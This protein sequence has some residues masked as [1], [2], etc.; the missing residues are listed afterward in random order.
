M[1]VPQC[2]KIHYLH[3][4][5]LTMKPVSEQCKSLFSSG[6]HRTLQLHF[7]FPSSFSFALFINLPTSKEETCVC[8]RGSHIVQPVCW[9]IYWHYKLS[10]LQFAWWNHFPLV[11]EPGSSPCVLGG[12]LGTVPLSDHAQVVPKQ[13]RDIWK[14]GLGHK[15]LARSQDPILF[16]DFH[17]QETLQRWCS[18]GKRELGNIIFVFHKHWCGQTK[19]IDHAKFPKEL[20]LKNIRK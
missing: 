5:N 16:W 14:R 18:V 12:L 1:P 4:S 20:I 19:T 11:I 8:P 6:H 15:E 9:F 7:F 17:T 2:L 3:H 13:I 10:C